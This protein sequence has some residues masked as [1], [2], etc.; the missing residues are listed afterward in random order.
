[1][2]IQSDRSSQKLFFSIPVF[3][4]VL[5]LSQTF[6]SCTTTPKLPPGIDAL[7]ESGKVTTF[8]LLGINDFH[9]ALHPSEVNNADENLSV[10][11]A[12]A[13]M[14]ASYIKQAKKTFGERLLVL[15]AG[16]QWEGTLDS[17]YFEGAPVVDFFNEIGLRAAGVGEH[18]FDFGALGHTRSLHSANSG[19]PAGDILGVFKQ[20]LSQAR[21]PFLAANLLDAQKHK[22]LDIP[23]LLP[24]L[25]FEVQG[26]KIGLIGVTTPSI[27]PLK[28]Q[29]LQSTLAYEPALQS[30]L[31]ESQELKK[32]GAELIFLI[33]HMGA[34]CQNLP[35]QESIEGKPLWHPDTPQGSCR[36][37]DPLIQLMKA[38]PPGTVHA[39]VSGHS[40]T[41]I[42]HWV[43]GIPVI[44]SG[45]SGSYLHLVYLPY[46]REKKQILKDQVR[47]EGPVP[48]CEQVFATQGNCNLK[49]PPPA[50]GRGSLVDPVFLGKSLSPDSS[51]NR[52]LEDLYEKAKG[53]KSRVVGFAARSIEHFKL[54]ESPLANLVADAMRTEL[55][56]DFALINPGSIRSSLPAG[57]ITQEDVF[58]VLPFDSHLSIIKVT[59]KQLK[60]ILQVATCGAR[61]MVGLSGLKL[62]LIDFAQQAPARDLNRDGK[63]SHWEVN[64]I[65]QIRDAQGNRLK[66]N[67]YYTLATT[68]FLATGGDDLEWAMTDIPKHNITL[69][70]AGGNLRETVS[71]FLTKAGTLNS[72]QQ[73]LV[74][75]QDPRVSLSAR[76]RQ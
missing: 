39:V 42:H 54:A 66:N 40:H 76:S 25:L 44:Q 45:A 73:P 56:T 74:N 5:A 65:L 32:K 60:T 71:R 20:R 35:P 53:E 18:D 4:A 17:N 13:A 2:S 14:L 12:G 75:D 31:R 36:P 48:I 69:E 3:L 58:R 41:L 29:G 1:M 49:D 9:G 70:A 68:D 63:V 50:E 15:D 21:Y 6:L 46:D 30:V 27:S 28:A 34:S 52:I 16:D 11:Y 24:H 72:T 47:I 43:N 38:L 64:R 8:V 37:K 55:G 62:S 7:S 61:G 51:M 22:R 26:V 57:V 23:N 19:E 33:A 10:R 59:G 67:H